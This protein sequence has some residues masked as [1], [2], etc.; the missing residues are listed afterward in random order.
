M[1]F[2]IQGQDLILC[3]IVEYKPEIAYWF[4]FVIWNETRMVISRFF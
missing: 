3:Q 1:S 2:S 4:L